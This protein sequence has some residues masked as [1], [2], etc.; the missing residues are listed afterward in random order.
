M[1]QHFDRPFSA[2]LNHHGPYSTLKYS[3]IPWNLPHIHSF[4]TLQLCIQREM[5]REKNP[6]THIMSNASIP[7]TQYSGTGTRTPTNFLIGSTS[8]I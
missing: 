7:C 1:C 8:K 6:G 2:P 3:N 4:F 5:I